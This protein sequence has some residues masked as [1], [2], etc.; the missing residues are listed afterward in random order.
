MSTQCLRDQSNA[1][2]AVHRADREPIRPRGTRARLQ[3]AYQRSVRG[4]HSA[5]HR[6]GCTLTLTFR[7]SYN[8]STLS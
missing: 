6:L 7:V 4:P 3:P 8:T 2:E 1:E 5:H